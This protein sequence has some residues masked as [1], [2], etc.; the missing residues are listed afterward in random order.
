MSIDFGGCPGTQTITGPDSDLSQDVKGRL[1]F[2]DSVIGVSVGSLQILK[3]LEAKIE[4]IQKALDDLWEI[5]SVVESPLLCAMHLCDPAVYPLSFEATAKVLPVEL[6]PGAPEKERKKAAAT[7]SY[8]RTLVLVHPSVESVM[9]EKQLVPQNWD[10]QF[11]LWN[12]TTKVPA[13]HRK[14]QHKYRRRASHIFT[15]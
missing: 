5:S 6:T 3:G 12:K 2:V 10:A 4:P 15:Y 7:M 14:H 8:V 13:Q 1:E 11:W 9:N